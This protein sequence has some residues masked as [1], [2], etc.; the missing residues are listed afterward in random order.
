MGGARQWFGPAGLPA[1][2]LVL[3]ALVFAGLVP[4]TVG[5]AAAGPTYTYSPIANMPVG[6]TEAQ[7]V[8]VGD[9][10]YV[11]GGFD[12]RRPC[13]TPTDRAW[14]YDPATNVWTA[15]PAMPDHGVSHAGIDSDGSRY[16]YYAGGY[17]ADAKATN[18]VYGTTEVWRFDTATGTYA[19]MPSLPQARAAGGLAYVGGRLYYLGGAN[20]ARTQDSPDVW[21]LD[22]AAG[23]TSW[24]SGAAMPNPRNHLGWA[25]IDGEI[26]V[27]GGQHL[28]DS[29]TAQGELDRYDPA[30]N[31]WTTLAVMP[32]ARSHVMDSSFVLNGRLIVAGGWTITSVSPSVTAYDP[33]TNSWQAWPEL[34]QARTSAT[35]RS[36][37]AGRFV[38]CCGSAG[39]SNSSGWIASPPAAPVTPQPT[40]SPDVAPTT[41]AGPTGPPPPSPGPARHPPAKPALSHVTLHPSTVRAARAGRVTVAFRL[42]RSAR[43]S[44]V[45]RRCL[46]ARCTV[47]ARA[48]LVAPA[49]ASHFSLRAL[50][51]RQ[52]LPT[53]HYRLTLTP[54][55][56]RALTLRIVVRR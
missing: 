22:V 21:I 5:A 16:V 40:R 12:V 55:G 30:G 49:G 6:T 51:H 29:S 20:L 7:S 46:P 52:A 53:A 4:L 42:N 8:V 19:R 24:V 18:Q 50:A 34:P 13:C 9:T 37:S 48:T 54:V 3:L 10:L 14:R 38:F 15:L 17:A 25:V 47:A 23:S 2:L 27:A 45:L 32:V 1:L 44:V 39:S 31:V 11:F 43:L 28:N 56:G 35:V 33:G 26:Y 41:G 36:V